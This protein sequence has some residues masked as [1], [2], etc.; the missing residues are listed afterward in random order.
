M[1]KKLAVLYL[2]LPSGE[3]LSRQVVELSAEGHV[4]RYYPLDCELAFAEWRAET[5][6]ITVD[7]R[8]RKKTC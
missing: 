8:L 2:Q 6:E 7:G 5:Y 1:V 3:R 4:V